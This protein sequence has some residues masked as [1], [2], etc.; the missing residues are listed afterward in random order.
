MQELNDEQ[1]KFVVGVVATWL[2]I[3]YVDKSPTFADA[4][5]SA[6]LKRLLDG[7]Q[8]LP[9]PPPRSYSYPW[10]ELVEN[11]YEN[12]CEVFMRVNPKG[13]V[14]SVSINQDDRWIKVGESNSGNPILVHP[15]MQG[16][17]WEVAEDAQPVD[18]TMRWTVSKFSAG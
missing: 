3:G 13:E 16:C 8:A 10:Y 14:V 15:N 5:H 12:R 4:V 17:M 9:E 6:L 7:K 18:A 2:K 11:G 1:K